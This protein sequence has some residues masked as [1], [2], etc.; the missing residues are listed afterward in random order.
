VNR[1]SPIPIR[2]MT[3][4]ESTTQGDAGLMPESPDQRVI[5]K[6]RVLTHLQQLLAELANEKGADH[7][8]I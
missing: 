8:N 6:P 2:N 5:D 7:G 3:T 4:Q 1:S